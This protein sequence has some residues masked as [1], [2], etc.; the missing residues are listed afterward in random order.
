LS[1]QVIEEMQK[2]SGKMDRSVPAEHAARM[3]LLESTNAVLRNTKTNPFTGREP[4]DKQLGTVRGKNADKGQKSKKL[5][6]ELSEEA[7][8]LADKFGYSEENLAELFN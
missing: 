1:N 5:K 3:L 6:V 2:R 8:K 7:K 4:T